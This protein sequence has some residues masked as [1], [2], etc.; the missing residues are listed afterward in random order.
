LIQIAAGFHHLEN[1]NLRGTL[2]L[3]KEGHEKLK[4]RTSTV[5]GLE[6]H[7]FL[8]QVRACHHSIEALGSGAFDGFDR[9]MIPKM[10]LLS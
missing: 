9:G 6:L 10:Y 4:D 1:G 8:E 7:Q 3:L 2:S 5:A